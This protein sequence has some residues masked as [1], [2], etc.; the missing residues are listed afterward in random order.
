VAV[1]VAV[2]VSVGDLVRVAVSERVLRGVAVVVV[3][4][5]VVAA[6]CGSVD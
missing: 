2:S 3:A 6:D 1:L 5:V 4:V